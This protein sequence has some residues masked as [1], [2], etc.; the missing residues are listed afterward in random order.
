MTKSKGILPPRRHW[1][2]EETA[3]FIRLYPDTPA[4]ELAARF[5][6]SIAVIY[7]RAKKLG[8]KKSADFVRS[9]KSG[10]M[11]KG[12]GRGGATRFQKGHPSWNK[13]MKG[14]AFPGSEAGWFKPGT[15]GGRA[16][17]QYQPIGTEVV[18]DGY[19]VRKMTDEG[20]MHKRWRFVHILTWEA[21]NGPVPPGHA[22]TFKDGNRLN[23]ALDNLELISRAELARRNGF[24][25]YGPEIASVMRLRGKLTR[26]I[27]RQKE[28]ES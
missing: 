13:G 11:L 24:C 27:N 1:T 9:E 14:L 4:A 21:E 23:C 16:A 10:R 8:V 19:L 28:K 25:R 6:V 7:D 2:E 20:L 3:D 22:V 12:D 17:T 5:G 18:R 15:R 26:M